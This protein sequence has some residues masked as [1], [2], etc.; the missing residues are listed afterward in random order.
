MKRTLLGPLFGLTLLVAAVTSGC[1]G[2][3]AVSSA[4]AALASCNTYCDAYIAQ[5][6]S[7]AFY[8]AADECKSTKCQDTS[9]GSASCN[10]ALKA[11]Y[12]CQQSQPDICADDGCSSQ[13]AAIIGAC[14]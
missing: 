9:A 14:S 6:C 7:P 12:D 1:D 2:Q 11:Y 4:A 5:A 13:A 3:G 8:A 10:A